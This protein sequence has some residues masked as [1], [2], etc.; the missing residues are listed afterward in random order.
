MAVA[1]LRAGVSAVA[2]PCGAGTPMMGY[3][4][5]QG[6]ADGEHDPLF[7][8][9]LFLTREASELLWVQC[10]LCLMGPAQAAAVRDRIAVRTGVAREH[11]L[12]GC[13]HTHSGPDTGLLQ[14]LTGK[15]E[16]AY[17]APLFDAIV[18]AAAASVASAAPARLWHCRWR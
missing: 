9:A 7:A 6:A 18:E 1:E 2:L 13:I 17:V 8:R 11:V 12:L 3:G 5:R 10:D 16:P 4:A 14:H 15:P